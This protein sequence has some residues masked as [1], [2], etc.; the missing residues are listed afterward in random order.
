MLLPRAP[1]EIPE[2]FKPISRFPVQ[3][4]T[5]IVQVALT[6]PLFSKWPAERPRPADTK[7]G[8]PL[9]DLDGEVMFA[10]L[11]LL[12]L[13]LRDGWEGRWIDN[14]PLP[15]TFRLAYWDGSL[16]K[17]SRAQADRG[18]PTAIMEVYQAIC[19][20]AGDERGGGAWDVVAWRGEEM[21]FLEAKRRSS[22]DKLRSEQKGWLGAALDLRVPLDCFLFAEWI[23]G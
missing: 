18:L 16:I 20:H 7:G 6:R 17:V 14:Y 1:L 13:L 9:V 3:I 19:T 21:L 23:L 22:G 4:G 12:T 15:P 10:E 11:A 5:D 2:R 8:K